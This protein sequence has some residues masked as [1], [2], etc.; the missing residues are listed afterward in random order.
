MKIVKIFCV[1]ALCLFNVAAFAQE[2]DSVINATAIIGTPFTL[3]APAQYYSNY[4][5]LLPDGSTQTGKT[6]T[7][8]L[9]KYGVQTFQCIAR[10]NCTDYITYFFV[11]VKASG[12]SVTIDANI[13]VY[14][15]PASDVINIQLPQNTSGIARLQ[16]I[17]GKVLAELVI[18]NTDLV[19]LDVQHCASGVYLLQLTGVN[20]VQCRQVL[21]QR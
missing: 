13:K 7:T 21:I 19:K 3:T 15:N 16:D 10:D 4:Q 6:M 14:P 12:R 17:N 8:T 1:A 18:T 11:D 20:D 2:A 9:N 5:W